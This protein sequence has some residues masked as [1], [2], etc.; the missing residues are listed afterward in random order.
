MPALRQIVTTTTTQ[1]VK[2]APALKKKLMLKLNTY[3]ALKTERDALNLKLNGKRDKKTKE[4]LVTGLSQEVEEILEEV[5]QE[6]LAIDGYKMT[7]IAPVKKGKFNPKKAIALGISLQQIE[8]CY[9]ADEPGT[10][11][12]KITVPGA[13]EDED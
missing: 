7:V 1:V 3:K 6:K 11:Y 2:L 4:I 12:V 5:G 13:S 8:Q 10:S 9:D